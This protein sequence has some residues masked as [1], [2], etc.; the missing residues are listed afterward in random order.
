MMVT[1]SYALSGDI[2]RN[3]AEHRILKVSD[4]VERL[5]NWLNTV[6]ALGYLREFTSWLYNGKICETGVLNMDWTMKYELYVC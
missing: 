3:L 2:Y 4:N 5:S 1:L 6:R